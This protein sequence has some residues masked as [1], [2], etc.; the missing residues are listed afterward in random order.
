MIEVKDM[1]YSYEDN[2]I[3]RKISFSLE[4]GKI[5]T[6]IG[7]SGIGKTTLLKLMAGISHY[8]EGTVSIKGTTINPKQHH[9]GYIPQH[10][11]L[12]PW[13]NVKK[14]ILLPRKLKSG[15]KN[16][17]LDQLDMLCQELRIDDILDKYPTH[18][19]GGQ[20]QRVAIARALY[21]EPEILLMDEPFA[22]LDYMHR[23]EARKLFLKVWEQHQLTTIM[24]THDILEAIYLGH[25]IVIL[26][27]TDELKIYDNPYVQID[28]K[29]NLKGIYDYKEMLEK[30][31]GSKH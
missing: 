29:D 4:E 7:K 11:G 31:M 20:K 27:G 13:Y 15:K 5:C 18:I 28:L 16:V 14:N 25:S 22:S 17:A 24:V 6:L 19:S 2:K 9:I 12:I 30:Y 26:S 21:Q 23:D 10:Y 8:Q 3:L 1:S